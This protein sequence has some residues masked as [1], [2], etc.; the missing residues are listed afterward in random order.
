MTF[1]FRHPAPSPTRL[2]P[3][4]STKSLPGFGRLSPPL[5][6]APNALLRHTLSAR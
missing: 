1:R 6:H 4:E 3:R 2:A 5:R